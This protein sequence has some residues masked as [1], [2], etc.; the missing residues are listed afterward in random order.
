VRALTKTGLGR[1]RL[2]H[3]EQYK[4]FEGVAFADRTPGS[5]LEEFYM[6]VAIEADKLSGRRLELS[7]DEL[8]RLQTLEEIL[9]P[10]DKKS[11]RSLSSE[12][13]MS[14]WESPNR[15]GDPLADYWEY[16]VTRGLP[17]DLEL[18]EVPPRQQWDKAV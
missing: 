14:V 11:L 3:S 7:G 5:L 10:E 17:V 12:D 15:T 8:E 18:S 9:K 4:P 13:S 16:R 6:G 1:L 2:W